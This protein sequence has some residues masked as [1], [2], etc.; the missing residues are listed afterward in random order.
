M[1][2]DRIHSD[3]FQKHDITG[4]S[5]LQPF[6]RHSVAAVFNHNRLAVKFLN[7]GKSL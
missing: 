5:S 6:L 7:K 1:D 2:D 3:E 4:E